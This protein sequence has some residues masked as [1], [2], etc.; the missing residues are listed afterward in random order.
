MYIYIL[1]EVSCDFLIA[2]NMIILWTCRLHDIT[3]MSSHW[4]YIP[5]CTFIW[6][7]VKPNWASALFWY[8]LSFWTVCALLNA[9]NIGLPIKGAVFLS[10]HISMQTFVL[11]NNRKTKKPSCVTYN[12]CIHC[13]LIFPFLSL[14]HSKYDKLQAVTNMG[15]VRI[16]IGMMQ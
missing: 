8:F 2:R 12:A 4:C 7:S 15:A 13:Y 1:S 10:S 3:V 16:F 5:A 6:S 11:T 14:H 9:L